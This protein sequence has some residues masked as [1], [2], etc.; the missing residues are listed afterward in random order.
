MGGTTVGKQTKKPAATIML[1]TTVPKHKNKIFTGWA[2]SKNG[3]VVYK[4]GDKYKKDSD[5]NLYAK[6]RDGK[7]SSDNASPAGLKNA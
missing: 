2:T 4:P 7:T 5:L 6:W 1:S 3:K